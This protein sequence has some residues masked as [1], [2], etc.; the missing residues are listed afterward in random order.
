MFVL[1]V[2]TALGIFNPRGM[3][4]YGRVQLLTM[5]D[6]AALLSVHKRTVSR[7]V[8]RGDLHAYDIAGC[9]RLRLTDVEEYIQS[10]KREP[11]AGSARP[12]SKHERSPAARQIVDDEVAP[13]PRAGAFPPV[14]R[15]LSERYL[16]AGKPD[17]DTLVVPDASGRH[18][19]RQNW[20]QRTWVP[21]L[22]GAGVSYFRPY[23]LR[24]TCATLLIYEGRTVNEVA[25]HLGHRD[26]GFS[27]R[28]Y[29]HIYTDAP[30]AGFPSTRRF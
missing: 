3:T 16:A 7:L 18:L 20:R 24:H 14:A 29:Q 25:Q 12:S 1:L 26:P 21:A 28:T 11:P 27:A 5:S 15:D 4:S 23:D 9:A 10:S 19:R 17:P 30:I 13:L 22:R 8:E 6:A 2:A